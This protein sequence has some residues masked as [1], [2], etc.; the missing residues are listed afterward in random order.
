MLQGAIKSGA[1][2]VIA[3][4]VVKSKLDIAKKSGAD[5]TIDAN[6]VDPIKRVLE[7]TDGEGVDVA[8]EAIGGTGIGIV[9]AL[10]MVKHNGI[11]VLY[12]DNYVPVKEFCF[13]RFHEDGLEIRNLNAMHYTNLRA[14]ENMREAYRAVQRG[15]FNLNIILENS[16]RY[17]LDEIADVF[18]KEAEALDTQT[19]LKTLIIP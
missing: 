17:K 14:I 12:G 4:D 3:V 8:I 5:F 15:V 11:M 10:G 18:E 9:Q 1:S 13:H 6:E 7:L 19:S 16:V 2:K